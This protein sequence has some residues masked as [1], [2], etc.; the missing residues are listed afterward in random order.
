[1]SKMS[2]LDVKSEQNEKA[3][4]SYNAYISVYN[5]HLCSVGQH[6]HWF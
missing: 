1:M 4:N 3:L 6:D 5:C 2:L